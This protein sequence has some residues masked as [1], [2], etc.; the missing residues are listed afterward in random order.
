MSIIDCEQ[1][2]VEQRLAY[3]RRSVG[4]LFPRAQVK[5]ADK[6]G[7]KG[8]IEWRRVGCL[9]ISHISSV[10]QIVS[11]SAADVDADRADVFELNIQISG[12]GILSQCGQTAQTPPGWMALYD[13]ARPFTMIFEEPFTQLSL[14]FPQAAL[15]RSVWNADAFCALP[16]DARSGPGHILRTGIEHIFESPADAG[17][18]SQEAQARMADG[19]LSLLAAC[20]LDTPDATT[21]ARWGRQRTLRRLKDALLNN[22]ED[23][24]F[25]PQQA[26]T[27]C[28]ISLR[29]AHSLFEAEEE[30]LAQWLKS[31]RLVAA[32]YALR[33]PHNQGRPIAE[34]AFSCGFNDASA[35]SKA[36]KAR[37]KQAPK[38]FRTQSQERL[39]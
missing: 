8:T 29:Y 22:L 13:S 34:I 26:A 6:H 31:Q 38:D 9:T 3:W 18:S 36:F 11:R 25:T 32:T 39:H 35:F 19:F 14:Q 17:P 37:Y 20:L 27:Q 15:R 33:A 12:T 28:G 1:Q 30:T 4:S 7:F 24:G 23:P 21:S 16:I 2:P 10:A 5:E